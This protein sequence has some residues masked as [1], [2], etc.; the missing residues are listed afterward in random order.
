MSAAAD[1][2][3]GTTAANGCKGAAVDSLIR[4]CLH[5]KAEIRLQ[6]LRSWRRGYCDT[7]CRNAA[8]SERQNI[9]RRGELVDIDCVSC[10]TTFF[11]SNVSQ[12][13]CH[14]ACASKTKEIRRKQRHLLANKK[15]IC[16]HCSQS[17]EQNRNRNAI[18]CAGC[19]KPESRRK[20]NCKCCGVLLS[21]RKRSYCSDCLGKTKY[22][23]NRAAQYNITLHEYRS[24]VGRGECDIC[25]VALKERMPSSDRYSE[26]GHIDHDHETGVVRGYL[27]RYCNHMIG[28]AMDDP[29][30]LNQAI[31]YLEKSRS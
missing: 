5:C 15:R 3:R 11:P 20:A 23:R 29:A 8:K 22:A 30:R 31:K 10:G 16:L 7:R 2:V 1:P 26:V 19:A 21:P 24:L 12:K 14:R 17:I 18:Y 6:S 4:S 28:N 9:K 13:Y 27:C 25:H